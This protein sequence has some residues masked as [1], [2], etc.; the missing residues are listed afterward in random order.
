MHQLAEEL[1]KTLGSGAAYRLLS[2]FGRRIYFPKGI[3]AQS[4][5][6]REQSSEFNATAGLALAS[7]VPMTL[8]ALDALLPGISPKESVD[9]APTGGIKGLREAWRKEILRKNPSCDEKTFGLPVVTPGLTAGISQLADLFIDEGD[10]VLLPE[11]FWGNYT[12]IFA[13][14]RQ[15]EMI[16]FPFFSET[17]GFNLEGFRRAVESL[18]DRDKLLVLLNFPNNPTGYTPTPG[19]AR[20]IVEVLAE[21]GAAGKATLAVCD[22]A[23]FGL[24]YEAESF[25]E[26]LFGLLAKAQENIL[27]VKVDGATK[28]EFAWGLR[29]GFLTFGGTGTPPEA[30]D[31]LATK[32]TGSLR[33]AISNSSNLGQHLVLRLLSDP[34]HQKQKKEV[35]EI[36]EKRYRKVRTIIAEMPG[37]TGLSPLPFNSGYFMAFRCEGISPEELRKALLRKGVGTISLGSDIL[38]VAY[39]A[40]DEELLPEIYSRIFAAAK[41]LRKG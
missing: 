23:Y 31:A 15:G 37:D 30:R 7:G 3:V 39:A 10:A 20:G 28:E 21:R 34:D 13:Q 8:P 1:N 36:L 18:A 29:V 24:T 35:R 19:E 12:L 14:R 26:S 40:V 11:L 6:A 25:T 17:G 2:D 4:A 9:Y 16:P 38:R 32:L 27:A 5:E 41:E 22:D 33:A